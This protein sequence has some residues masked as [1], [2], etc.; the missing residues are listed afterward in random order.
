MNELVTMIRGYALD[1]YYRYSWDVVATR[2]SD[3]EI[4]AAIVGAKT[5][6]GAL[7]K[8]WG[9]LQ[10]IDRARPRYERPVR[11]VS[12]IEFLAGNGGI[13][14]DE[15]MVAEIRQCGAGR[16]IRAPKHVSTA[17]RMGHV[18]VPAFLDAA[19]EAAIEAGYLPR[20]ATT[21]ELLEAIDED[22][23][24][25]KRFPFGTDSFDPASVELDNREETDDGCPF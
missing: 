16:L 13:R 4:A 3:A 14:S 12:L 20:G 19:C 18:K 21:N 17:M 24:G 7:A 5:R 6:R 2:W 15:K 25:R 9:L 22:A 10:Q 1:N 8:T 11:P 23:R